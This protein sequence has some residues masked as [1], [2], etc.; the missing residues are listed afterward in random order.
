MIRTKGEAGTGDI[1]HAVR[2]LRE[3]FGEIRKLTI[4]DPAELMTEAKTLGA[5]FELVRWV[6]ENGKL[7][8]PN[9]AAG[10]I[11]T[12]ADA[13]LCRMLGA[14]AVFVGSGIFK[15][16][17][18]AARGR[19][20]VRASTHWDDPKALLEI[21]AELGEPM[22]GIFK[23]WGFPPDVFE[24][25]VGEDRII[26][27]AVP[28]PA[29]SVYGFIEPTDELIE[30]CGPLRSLC[31]S[32]WWTWLRFDIQQ[33]AVGTPLAWF[34]TRDG[35]RYPILTRTSDNAYRFWFNLD[36][37]LR[38][39][40]NEQYLVH[41]PPGYLKLGV[42]PDRLP[43]RVRKI[44][45]GSLHRIRNIRRQS[46]PLF[47]AESSDPSVDAWRYVIRGI[48]E[49]NTTAKAVPLWPNGKLC[50]ATINSDIDTDYCF[51]T[52]KAL[53]KLRDAIE[54]VG[55][56]SA[57]LVVG[58]IVDRGRAV[59]DD[60][61]E[62][63]HEIGSHDMY[64]DHKIAF[65]P[66][67][68]IAH[69]LRCASALI[70]RY[71]RAGFRSP[72]YLRTPAL[73]GELDGVFSYDMS[74][75]DTIACASGLSRVQEGCSTCFPFHLDRTNVLEIPTTVP[76][77]WDLEL[78]GCSPDQA[79]RRQIDAISHLKQRGGIAN[80]CTHPEPQMTLR[81][82]WLQSHARVLEWLADDD[83]VWVARPG[84][85]DRH[86]RRRQAE[87]DTIWQHAS[88]QLVA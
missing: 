35:G 21:S 27:S 10:G 50:A 15:S 4:M 74:M 75:H 22:R 83:E 26:N 28:E 46:G 14:E 82:E 11:A 33:K 55:M 18:P 52:P 24:E 80:I 84:D 68:Q 39:I 38:L 67:S 37:T 62:A 60:L 19:A 30:L 5:P 78:S 61:H 40:E 69:R 36:A 41:S 31:S 29:T 59:L 71:G 87:I 9:F 66:P 51:R 13:A 44:A 48:V 70:E 20:I 23:F 42:N 58:T 16:E 86:W 63:G 32:G 43:S 65:L 2:H 25:L 12:P 1:V 56:R 85:I 8:V 3:V 47:P 45:F 76:E 17:D 53:H 77:D 49:A 7:P 64:H 79:S 6:A 88:A 81:P 73:Y 57:W 72:S 54:R 34:R